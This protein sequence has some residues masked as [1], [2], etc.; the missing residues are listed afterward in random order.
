MEHAPGTVALLDAIVA[1]A[2]VGFGF[3]DHGLRLRHANAALTSMARADRLDPLG[4]TPPELLGELGEALERLLAGVLATERPVV[5]RSVRGRTPFSDEAELEWVGAYYPVF[6]D[7]GGLL[8]VAGLLRETTPTQPV[9]D[10]QRALHEALVARTA[11]ETARA[12]TAFIAQAG[13]RMATSMDATQALRRL[14]RAAVPEAADWCTISMLDREGRLEPVA[15]AHWDEGQEAALWAM[16][17]RRPVHIDD[18]EGPAKALRLGE[19]VL[20][21]VVDDHD[22]RAI[23][24]DERHLEQLRKLGVTSSL[25]VPLRSPQRAIGT[26]TLAYSG[27]GRRYGEEDVLMAEA[28]AAWAG[29]HV[30]NARLYTERSVIAT[31]LQEGL[32]PAQLPEVPGVD[33]AVRYRPAGEQ[34]QVGGDFYDVFATR[35]GRWAA[36]IGDVSGKGASAAALTALARHTLFA[37]ALR[38]DDAAASLRLLN[39]AILLRGGGGG[40]GAHFCTVVMAELTREATGAVTV[41]MANGGHP[42]PFVVRADGTVEET[43]A[44]GT[45]IGVVDHPELPTQELTLRPGDLLVAYTDGATELRGPDPANGERVLRAALA[46]HAGASAGAMAAAIERAIVSAAGGELIDDFAL[47]VLGPAL[48]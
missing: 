2:P 43:P 20:D 31:T 48:T 38:G 27:S 19:A 7:D 35:D 13:A 46:A 32:L 18:P 17:A 3:W 21:E 11:A 33:L 40:A 41:R 26:I 42:A 14:A 25:V 24:H 37:A 23:A 16:V 1:H 34:N 22:L 5:V 15:V 44:G 36:V 4:T 29:L 28:L 6:R 30:E 8:G 39:D 9:A 47:L 12:R 45:L 10:L